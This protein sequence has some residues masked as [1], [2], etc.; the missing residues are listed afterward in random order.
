[1]IM[2]SKRFIFSAFCFGLYLTLTSPAVMACECAYRG[3]GS[4]TISGEFNSSTIV[5]TATMTRAFEPTTET[6]DINGN[7]GFRF[8]RSF[9]M[10][11]AKVYK[12][13]VK[14]GDKLIFGYPGGKDCLKGFSDSDVGKTFLFYLQK[15]C[16]SRRASGSFYMPPESRSR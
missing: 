12:G 8:D 10:T 9:E 13:D 5:I 11:V 2:F 15:P 6:A 3:E 4:G 14:T 16:G 7:S 1:M